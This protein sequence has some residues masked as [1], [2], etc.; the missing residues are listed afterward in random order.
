MRYQAAEEKVE[1]FLE[2]AHLN[3]RKTVYVLHGH[4]TGQLKSGIRSFCKRSQ[5]VKNYQSAPDFEG[6]D[7]LTVITLW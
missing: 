7:A 6:G 2:R 4:G 3:N 1:E 5:Y